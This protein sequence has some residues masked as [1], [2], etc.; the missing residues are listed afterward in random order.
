[1]KKK[2][3]LDEMQEQKLLKIEHNGCWIAFWGL[4]AVIVIQ[5]FLGDYSPKDVA[6]ETCVLMVISLYIVVDCIK[7]G[8]WARNLNSGVKTNAGFSLLAGVILGLIFFFRSYYNYH[9]LVSSI[10]TFIFIALF[11]TLICFAA[12]SF[13]TGLYK[14]QRQKLESYEDED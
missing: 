11:T 9:V 5:M 3:N 4:A 14:K 6:G 1:M 7:N 8:I 12:L 13:A 2:S 10:A